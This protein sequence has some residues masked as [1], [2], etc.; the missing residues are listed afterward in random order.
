[1]ISHYV[2]PI[3]SLCCPYGGF[4]TIPAV[5]A[6]FGNVF[7]WIAAFSCKFVHVTDSELHQGQRFGAGLWRVRIDGEC[8]AFDFQ[9]DGTLRFVRFMGIVASTLAP[10]LFILL[11]VVSCVNLGAFYI[12]GIAWGFL[13]MAVTNI[14][15]L[16]RTDSWQSEGRL[17]AWCL[18]FTNG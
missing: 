11:L 12:K 3:S 7:T 17:S 14:L 2:F 8:R 5:L 18:L 13:F 9:V 6:G 15:L 1:M 16:V 4:E 10:I